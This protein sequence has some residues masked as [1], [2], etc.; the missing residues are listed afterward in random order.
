[1]QKETVKEEETAMTLT[2]LAHDPP[3]KLLR[4]QLRPLEHSLTGTHPEAAAH[5]AA[6]SPPNRLFLAALDRVLEA[7]R[8][9]KSQSKRPQI[10]NL[11]YERPKRK[12]GSLPGFR[13]EPRLLYPHH[14]TPT[15]HHTP[16]HGG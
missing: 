15:Q 1:M 8:N 10:S 12:R 6:W 14:P 7:E 2:T 13:G 5:Q 4:V 3:G 16:I 9:R 11:S